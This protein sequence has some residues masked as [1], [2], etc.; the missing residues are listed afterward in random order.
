M[1]NIFI[2]TAFLIFTAGFAQNNPV[3]KMEETEVKTKM[4]EKDGEMIETK[5]K[6]ITKKEQEIMI[7]PA[8]KDMR[9]P[10]Q[11]IPPTKVTKTIMVDNDNDP[12]YDNKT[13]L[14]YYS[15]NDVKYAFKADETGFKLVTQDGDNEIIFGN[16]VRSSLNNYYIV[17]LDDFSGIGYF[18][19]NGNL[20]VEYYNRDLNVLV[21]ERFDKIPF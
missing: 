11:Y 2:T 6:V 15:F 7:N 3:D 13:K 20:V 8:Q 9:D 17:S 12:F 4:V 18:D 14:R 19:D 5:V 21:S 10:D 16:A 1:K